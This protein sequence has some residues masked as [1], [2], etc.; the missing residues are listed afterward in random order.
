M[1]C[2]DTTILLDLLGRGGKRRRQRAIAKLHELLERDESLLTTRFNVAELYVGVFRSRHPD[3]EHAA[4]ASLLD[5]VGVLD[6]DANA[7]LLFGRLTAHLQ[8]IGRPAGDMDVMIAAVALASSQILI[9]DNRSHFA[10]LAPL[11]VE[12]Y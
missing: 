6:F 9:T 12:T 2:L 3:R 4:I 8:Q 7:A 11:E 10:H 5:D 1:A